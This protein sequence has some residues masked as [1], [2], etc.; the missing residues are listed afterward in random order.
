M[1][2]VMPEMAQ[3]HVSHQLEKMKAAAVWLLGTPFDFS[4]NFCAS[5]VKDFWHQTV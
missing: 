3:G 1:T 5:A 4:F 2:S